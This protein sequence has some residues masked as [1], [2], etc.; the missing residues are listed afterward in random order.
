MRPFEGDQK[1]VRNKC[2]SRKNESGKK[3]ERKKAIKTNCVAKSL[4][5]PSGFENI[6]T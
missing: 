4:R 6:Y 1:R 5:F 2:S 3:I